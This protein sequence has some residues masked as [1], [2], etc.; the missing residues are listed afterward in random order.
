MPAWLVAPAQTRDHVRVRGTLGVEP[1]CIALAGEVGGRVACTIYAQRPP[2]CRDFAASYE[3]GV[4]EPA[5]D[6]ARARH[7]L[8]P[9]TP[10]D[11]GR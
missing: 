2:P 1:R 8:P 3:A 4:A 9:L 7:G 6:A 5:C 10:A 11:W